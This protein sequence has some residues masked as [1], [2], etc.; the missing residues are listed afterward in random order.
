MPRVV[1]GIRLPRGEKAAREAVGERCLAD[2]LWPYEQPGVMQAPTPARLLE[3][4]DRSFMAEQAIDF[5]R[6]R[7]AFEPVWL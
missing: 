4:R 3:L 2:A 6:A 5:A 1:R 7:E